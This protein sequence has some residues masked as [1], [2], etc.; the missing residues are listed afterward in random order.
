M[1]SNVKTKKDGSMKLMFKSLSNYYVALIISILLLV[2][3]VVTTILGP[4]YIKELTELIQQEATTVAA[5][6]AFSGMSEIISKVIL[7]AVLYILSFVSGII[8]GFILNTVIQKYSRDLREQI[9]HKINLVPLNYYD[10]RQIGDILSV[11]TNDVDTLATQMQNSVT[12]LINSLLM[13]VGA[14]IAMFITKWQLA[15]VVLITL[16]LMVLVLYLTCKFALPLFDKNQ[17]VLG[18]VNVRTE[19]DYAGQLIIKSFN[20]T[21]YKGKAFLEKNK[22]LGKLLFQSQGIGGIIQPLMGFVSY[23]A[24][25][26]VLVVGGVMVTQGSAT[27]GDITAFLVYV[28]LFQEP[29]TMIGQSSNCLQLAAAAVGRVYGFLNE[30]ELS[31]ESNKTEN[32]LDHNN[33]KGAVEFKNV[34]FGYLP[35]NTLVKDFSAK[36]EPGMKVAVVGP[37]GAGKTT[38][39]NL[40][41]R[42]YEITGGDITIDGVSIKDM[43]RR[44]LHEVMGMILQETWIMNGTLRENIVYNIKD[45]DE[46]RLNQILEETNLAHYVSTLPNGLDTEIQAE[47]AL[48][49]GQKQLV[50]IARAMLENSPMMILDEATS[51]VDTRTEILISKAMDTLT[52]GRTS[53]CIAHRLSTIKNANLIL[54]M[55]DGDIV[56]T[57]THDSLMEL[58]GLYSEIYNAQFQ[59]A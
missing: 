22:L 23:I 55:K 50:T 25:A 58:G 13:L 49:A 30:E 26:A 32:L 15:I 5:G 1:S 31:D 53:F 27:F 21:E 10:T 59:S 56:E 57:G 16:P 44:E 29:L 33:I 35:E 9:S 28:S 18:E 20:A 39:V 41:M 2:V 51:N 43:S 40:L 48:S 14:I 4:G 38:L 52:T 3:S 42:F 12:M 36:I 6:Q 17:N 47:S 34:S 7:L 8:S 24:Y 45:V 37:T 54:V 46:D 19:E 11:V